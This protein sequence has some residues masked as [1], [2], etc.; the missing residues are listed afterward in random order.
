MNAKDRRLG[1][2][3]DI[4][5]P[6]FLNGVTLPLVHRYYPASSVAQDI[7]AQDSA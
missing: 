7:G 1:L 6:D 3:A 5:H 4:S 2:N